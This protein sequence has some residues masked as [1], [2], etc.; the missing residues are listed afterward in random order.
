M[1]PLKTLLASLMH[2]DPA[3]P[4]ATLGP[5]CETLEDR[6][7]LNGAW[8]TPP[9]MSWFPT[10]MAT[11][12]GTGEV[13]TL[14]AP[15]LSPTAAADLKT[16][17]TDTQTLQTE[18]KAKVAAPLFD[19]LKSDA[20]TIQKALGTSTKTW[21][22]PHAMSHGFLKGNDPSIDINRSRPAPHGIAPGANVPMTGAT[23]PAALVSK[24]ESAGVSSAQITQFENDA[25]ALQASIQ[26]VD[27][28]LMAKIQADRQ[29]LAKD[30]P[31]PTSGMHFDH[32][33]KPTDAA[34]MIRK[35]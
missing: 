20:A 23:L 5:V 18:I 35:A 13:H 7:L 10:T 31:T 16:L 33:I 22:G 25:K 1:S 4:R 26:K 32:I 12:P 30:A 21:S 27:P 19:A 8:T 24:L 14:A 2:G 34:P 29:V 6:R 9:G 3:R 17:Q 15:A 28:A 11:K